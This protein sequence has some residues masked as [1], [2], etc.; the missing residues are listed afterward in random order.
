[1]T[2]TMAVVIQTSFQVGHVTLAVS[3]RT[4]WRNSKGFVLAISFH[5]LPVRGERTNE[6]AHAQ[7]P[8]VANAALASGWIG[9]GGGS[10][11]PNLRFWRPTLY[12]LSYTPRG[13][14][15]N[16][17][18]HVR[19]GGLTFARPRS[20]RRNRHRKRS[21]ADNAVPGF[22]SPACCNVDF[23]LDVFRTPLI[24]VTRSRYKP[25]CNFFLDFGVRGLP[26]TNQARSRREFI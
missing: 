13:P 1:M 15:P 20:P 25:D 9:R 2:S 11:T 22:S 7:I 10:R 4:C 16:T 6:D 12:Q 23:R 18:R 17:V 26:L 19:S 5:S 21:A 14:P 3:C 8:A 24:E